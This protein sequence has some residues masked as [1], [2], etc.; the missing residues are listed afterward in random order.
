[1]ALRRVRI[2][3]LRCLADVELTLDPSHNYIF[4]PNG[5]G[6]TSILEAVFLLGRGR[7]FR[8]RQIRRLVRHGRGGLA[9]FGEVEDG[10][11]TRRIGVAFAHGRLDKKIDGSPASGTAALV[12]ILPVHAIDPSSHELIQ[13]GPSERRRFLDWGVFH[14]EHGY[15]EDWRRYRRLLGQRNAALKKGAPTAELATWTAALAEAGE[16]IDRSRTAY[17]TAL[18]PELALRGREL[19]ERP[20]A[21]T[22]ERGWKPDVPLAD[23]LGASE[24]RDRVFGNTEVGPHRA[25]L[26]LSMDGH[27]VHEEASRGQQKLAAASL[28]LAQATLFSRIRGRS[29]LLVDDPAAELD[30]AALE[31]LLSALDTVGAQLIVTGLTPAHPAPRQ[32]SGV[33]HVEHGVVRGL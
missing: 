25:D 8:T 3:D 13:G 27:R 15:L 14:V 32:G 5:A 17:V 26:A 28:I 2:T 12:E 18:G 24:S 16:S 11:R 21:L 4:G 33:F 20:L 6:K 19:L 1:L 23:A 22:L 9:V 10:A 31:R 29:A 30:S 7:S